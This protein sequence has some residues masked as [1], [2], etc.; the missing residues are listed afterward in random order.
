[1]SR[2]IIGIH[3]LGNKPPH[4]VLKDWWLRSIREGLSRSGHSEVFVPF[5]MVYWADLFHP[6]PLD[7]NEK[8]PE[9]PYFLEFPYVPAVDFSPQKI[10]KIRRRVLDFLEEEMGLGWQAGTSFEGLYRPPVYEPI[11]S[12]RGI[13]RQIG[14]SR[15][16]T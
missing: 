2:I 16:I 11:S 12:L 1:M 8:N 14:L 5:E 3:G 4:H 9:S 7:T 15:M 10:G 13:G 6:R